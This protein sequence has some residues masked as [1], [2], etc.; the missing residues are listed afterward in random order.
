MKLKLIP[1][2]RYKNLKIPRGMKAEKAPTGQRW[3]RF[4]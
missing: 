2:E 4:K 1:E 3:N